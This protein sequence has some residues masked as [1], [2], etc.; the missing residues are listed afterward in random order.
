MSANTGIKLPQS[1]RGT[2]LE[3]KSIAPFLALTFGLTW[4][5]A[6]LLLLFNDQI[7]AIDGQV[8]E[9]ANAFD[10]RFAT[11]VIGGSAKLGVMRGGRELSLH[12]ALEAAKKAWS[13]NGD[14]IAAFRR[15][16][17]KLPRDVFLR[18]RR[19]QPSGM[20]GLREKYQTT[21]GAVGFGKIFL[22][23]APNLG[24]GI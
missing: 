6:A 18:H 4:G 13:V 10:Y 5:L 16:L 19:Q 9:D 23:V 14:E 22:Q 1:P 21:E 15:W 7:V 11:K 12:V 17:H 8:V 2:A 24:S 3:T 20:Q